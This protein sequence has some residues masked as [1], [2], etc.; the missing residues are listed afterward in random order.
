MS[1]LDPGRVSMR[2]TAAS[3]NVQDMFSAS[4]SCPELPSKHQNRVSNQ[5]V[6]IRRLFVVST[7]RKQPESAGYMNNT[8]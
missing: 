7:R 5:A 1:D 4:A 6:C 2:R 8:L 3:S